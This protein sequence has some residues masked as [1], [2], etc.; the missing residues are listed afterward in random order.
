M[1]SIIEGINLVSIYMM[2]EPKIKR[3]VQ[4]A[5]G[6]LL[7]P[8]GLTVWDGMPVGLQ[9]GTIMEDLQKMSAS[10]CPFLLENKDCMIH[11]DRPMVCRA[12]GVFRDS[13]EVCPRPLGKGE[14]R[15]RHGIIENHDARMMV[16]DF[17]DDCRNRQPVWAIRTLLPTAIFRAASPKKFREYV[18]EKKIASAKL[19]GMDVDTS[20]MWQA[21]LDHLRKGDTPIE[22]ITKE[23]IDGISA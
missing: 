17:Y 19:L 14:T 13:V 9:H 8:H 10:Q 12:F 15:I 4:T 16:K 11:Q 23:V 5:E 20:L 2:D 18:E 22:L 3:L 7:E 21:Q 6:W 1:S